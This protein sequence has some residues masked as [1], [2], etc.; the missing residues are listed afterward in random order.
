MSVQIIPTNK[1]PTMPTRKGEHVEH[2]HPFPNQAD[3]SI[4]TKSHDGTE[5]KG[6]NRNDQG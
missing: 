5:I 4:P 6:N 1:R 3:V 2:K